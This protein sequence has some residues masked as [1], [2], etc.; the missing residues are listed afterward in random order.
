LEKTVFARFFCYFTA[1]SNP[2]NTR[3]RYSE[4]IG[5]AT[6]TRIH[7]QEKSYSPAFKL[8]A[9]GYSHATERE[10]ECEEGEMKITRERFF[11]DIIGMGVPREDAEELSKRSSSYECMSPESYRNFLETIRKKLAIPG[12]AKR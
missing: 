11:S 7:D 4:V 3:E 10:D 1:M 5:M 2:Q 9:S 12:L 8:Q 6:P